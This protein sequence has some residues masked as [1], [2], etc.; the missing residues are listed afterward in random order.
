[1]NS[2]DAH[3]G[4]RV[5]VIAQNLLLVVFVLIVFCGPR[6]LLFTSNAAR[7]IGSAIAI[8]GVILILF[9]VIS[10]RRVIQI[11]PEPKEG[12]QLIQ[13]GPYKYLRHPI[14]TGILWCVVGLFLR[15]PTIWIGIASL[16]IIVFLLL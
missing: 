12:G 5:Y 10:L 11:A 7:M 1:M 14:Y 16:L 4:S 13:T 9:A 2:S 3:R 8:I 6:N 15:T